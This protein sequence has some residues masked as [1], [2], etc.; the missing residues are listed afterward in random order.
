MI[1]RAPGSMPPRPGFPALLF[2]PANR[3]FTIV[4]VIAVVGLGA[5]L[6]LGGGATDVN[7]AE[8]SIAATVDTT[9]T[10]T[11]ESD[12]A[13]TGGDT[14]L[15]TTPDAVTTSPTTLPDFP[16]QSLA[17]EIVADGFTFPVF[18]TSPA[19]DDRIFVAERAGMIRVVDVGG[20]VLGEPFL[21][22]TDR[23]D[24]ASGVELG[25]LGMAFHPGYSTNGR[26]FV[27]YTD[28]NA[29]T[30]LAEYQVAADTGLAEPASEVVLLF[31]DQV[32]FRHRGG[33]IQFGPDGYL[34][35]GLGDGTGMSVNP[36]NL[37]T[38]QGSIL[39][40]DV[41]GDPP[42]T[43]PPD[44]PFAA[45]EGRGEIWAYGLRNPWRFSIDH[46]GGRIYIGDVGEESWEEIDSVAL[47]DP[48]AN[49]GWPF[50]EGS[51]CF[52][53]A[54]CGSRT[55]LVRPIAEYPHENGQCA[56]SGGYVYR[57]SA[58]PEMNGHY[59]YADWCVG[60][61]R[62]F[63]Y[64]GENTTQTQDWSEAFGDAV[65]QVDSF[66][67]DGAGELLVVVSD[68]GTIHRIVPVR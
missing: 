29:D 43:I 21:D 56:V 16:L 52:T 53:D 58:I 49:F 59:F 60:W 55:D 15:P 6:Y 30:V 1:Y 3:P 25:L 54:E 40:I 23:I 22:I 57:G 10:S 63:L 62:S 51:T 65:G 39:R 45:S 68:T 32:G 8:T 17:L 2:T 13:T 41:D 35:M 9:P 19:G 20:G 18:A 5:F 28:L 7:G 61:V 64:D 27:H 36:Q 46:D 44:N 38:L 24:S 31:V 12:P 42:Y 47:S 67:V 37:E 26:F 33:M 4:L 48:G 50:M 34:Y 66:G 11:A 14:T